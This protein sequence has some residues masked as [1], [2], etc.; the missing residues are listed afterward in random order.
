MVEIINNISFTFDKDKIKN[1]L[2]INS[3]Q[4]E[5]SF[6]EMV[7]QAKNIAE[8]MEFEGEIYR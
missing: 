1:K 3:A 2:M 4:D 6:E 7:I 5:N 8:Q